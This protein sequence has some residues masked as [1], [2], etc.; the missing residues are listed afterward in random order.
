MSRIPRAGP[1]SR[2]HCCGIGTLLASPPRKRSPC[3]LRKAVTPAAMRNNPSATFGLRLS[4]VNMNLTAPRPTASRPRRSNTFRSTV[5][6]ISENNPTPRVQSTP[7]I[8]GRRM[9][10]G[11]TYTAAPTSPRAPV[12]AIRIRLPRTPPRLKV[13]RSPSAGDMLASPTSRRS[14]ARTRNASPMSGS[15]DTRPAMRPL[16]STTVLLPS[17]SLAQR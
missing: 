3:A 7:L 15:A 8:S 11:I 12:S 2:S 5:I 13:S 14:T 4:A 17:D 6:T 10:P 9:R 16:T 1:T